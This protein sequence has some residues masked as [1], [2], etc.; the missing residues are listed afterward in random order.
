MCR[1]VSVDGRRKILKTDVLTM[2]ASRRYLW[3][4]AFLGSILAG[5]GTDGNDELGDEMLS[6]G[7]EACFL[8]GVESVG[9]G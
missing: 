7:R 4:L 8:G 5:I 6:T 1:R 9:E 3:E 2:E